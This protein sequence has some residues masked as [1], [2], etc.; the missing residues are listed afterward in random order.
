MFT[1]SL[2]TKLMA[3]MTLTILVVAGFILIVSY[4]F[5]ARTQQTSFDAEVESGLELINSSLLEPVFAYDFQQIDA[6]A[7]SLVNTANISRIAI[8]DHRGQDLASAGSEGTAVLASRVSRE[9]VEIVREGDVIGYYD[10]DFSTQ[11]MAMVLGNQLATGFAIAVSLMVA[12]LLTLFVLMRRIVVRPISTVSTNLAQIARGGGDLSSRLNSEGRDEVAQLADHYNQVMDHIAETLKSVVEVTETFDTHV[13]QMSEASRDASSSTQ[14]QLQ[15]L[16][17]AAAAI[18]QLAASADEVAS[19]SNETAERTR[20]TSEATEKG[21]Q[22][23]HSSQKNIQ[24]LTRQIEQT[25]NKIDSLKDSSQN[26]GKVIEVIRAIAEQTNLLALNAAIEA[27]RAGDQGRGFA[28]VADEVRTLAQRTQTS[29]EEIEQIVLQLQAAADEAHDSMETNTRWA[30]ETE[31]TGQQVEAVLESIRSHVGIINDMNHQVAS[32]AE[33][34]SASANEVS[35]FITSLFT[36]SEKVSGNAGL[37]RDSASQ[38]LQE[39]NELQDRMRKF[40]L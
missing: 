15:E 22:V 11:Q 28:V 35:R 13:Q 9:A 19:S 12:V 7:R 10:V 8:T 23:V 21:T 3:A 24:Q 4:Q 37:M 26:I 17:Q 38:L 32:A 2:T 27:A 5:M 40:T 39:N 18:N 20:D 31:E 25:A 16:E 34:Q 1:K 33:Q 6:I 36:L 30:R 14:Q 29:T